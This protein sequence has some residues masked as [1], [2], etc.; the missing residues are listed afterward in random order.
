ML[1]LVW[2]FLCV[3]V[4]LGNV[5]VWVCFCKVVVLMVVVFLFFEGV[6]FC[7]VW[8]WSGGWWLVVGSW[9]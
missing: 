7:F 2:D 4:F 8:F 5:G 3:V 9:W 1:C 6:V